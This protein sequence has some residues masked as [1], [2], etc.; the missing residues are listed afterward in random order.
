MDESFAYFLKNFGPAIARRDVDPAHAVQYRGRLPEQLL[1]YWT[2]HGFSGYADGLFWTVDPADYDDLLETWLAQ[3]PFAGADDYNVF[4]RTAFG[5]LFVWG[6]KSGASLRINSP[7]NILFPNPAA[8][9]QVKAGREDIAVQAFF[10]SKKREHFD[11]ADDAQKPLF[12]R[13]LKKLGPVGPDEIYG[14]E[15]AI[16]LG[17]KAA[18]AGLRKVEMLPHLEILAQIAPPKILENPLLRR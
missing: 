1:Q 5:E 16:P 3:T 6:K 18:L 13:A 8:A 12:A 7:L 2:E 15:P 17:G 14:F 10:V 4:A 11:F 9:D